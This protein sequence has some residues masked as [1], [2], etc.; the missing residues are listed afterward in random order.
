[1]N[2]GFSIRNMRPEELDFAA[3]C[4]LAEGWQGE[5][6][7]ELS[8]T[9]RR[10]PEGCFVAEMGAKPVGMCMGISYDAYGFLGGLIVVPEARGQGIGEALLRHT[11]RYLVYREKD[12]VFLD[13]VLPA[14]SLYERGGFQKVCRSLRFRGKP[15]GKTHPHVVPMTLDHLEDVCNLDRKAFGAER[16]RFLEHRLRL[17]P[18][19]CRA[20]IVE[21]EVAGYIM[22]RFGHTVLAA[23]PWIA[24]PLLERPQ[25]LLESLAYEHPLLPFS[26]GCLAENRKAVE[27]LRALGFGERPDSPWRMVY[28]RFRQPGNVMMNF[29]VG[30]PAKG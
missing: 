6:I 13:G 4:T 15:E 27:I 3:A 7:F 1:M 8:C 10:D 20:A 30:S 23:G 5:S 25:D 22:G 29:G 17:Y 28:G 14:V 19:L 21:G 12:S 2:K 18:A 11:V 26:I 24:S 9:Y 16:R